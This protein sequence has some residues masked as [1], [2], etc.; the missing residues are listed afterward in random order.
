MLK[1]LKN[2]ELPPVFLEG[3]IYSFD[4]YGIL[5][6]FCIYMCILTKGVEDAKPFN[7][8]ENNKLS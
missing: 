6:C 7:R 2:K 3:V 1:H 5:D 4:N 8:K